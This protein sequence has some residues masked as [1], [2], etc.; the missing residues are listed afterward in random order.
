MLADSM[1]S[2]KKP[3]SKVEATTVY[4]HHIQY[5]RFYCS[6]FIRC[7]AFFVMHF[8]PPLRTEITHIPLTHFIHWQLRILYH[9][10]VIP[11]QFY[12]QFS[13]QQV[14]ASCHTYN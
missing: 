12:F 11:L 13:K 1:H 9:T 7:Y 14:V 8:I 2:R 6:E 3:I 10:Q 5:V 4:N